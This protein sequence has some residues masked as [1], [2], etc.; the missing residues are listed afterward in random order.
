MGSKTRKFVLTGLMTSLVF[1]LTFIFPIPVPFTSGYIHLGDSM[2]YIS[3]IILGPFFGAFASGVGSMLADLLAGYA[4]YAIPTLIIKSTMA[5]VM[6]LIIS[7]KTRKSSVY[8]TI[9]ALTVWLAFSAGSVIYLKNQINSLGFEAL[10]EKIAGAD[11]NQEAINHATGLVNNL[12]LYLSLGLGLLIVILSAIAYLV[13]KRDGN[14]LFSLKAAIGMS[15]AGMCMVMGYFFVE[16][17]MYT[18]IAALLSVPMNMIQ[19]FAGVIAASLFAPAI[20]K[21]KVHQ[22]L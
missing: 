6:G 19:F 4:Q 14:K 17:F 8:S 20:T 1:V 11:A 2:I 10:V 7:G 5:L 16:S 18:P 13:S 9:T 12:P 21:I 22:P 3:V 15:A